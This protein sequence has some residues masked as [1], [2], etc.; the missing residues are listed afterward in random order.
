MLQKSRIKSNDHLKNFHFREAC[1]QNVLEEGVYLLYLKNPWFNSACTLFIRAPQNFRILMDFR[2]KESNCDSSSV[3]YFKSYI[4]LEKV[5]DGL[6]S[7]DSQKRVHYVLMAN[8]SPP[9]RQKIVQE[10]A[11]ND[12]SREYDVCHLMNTNP[13]IASSFNVAQILYRLEGDESYVLVKVTFAPTEPDC[14][15]VLY[16]EIE[17]RYVLTNHAKSGNCSWLIAGAVIITI[18]DEKLVQ[19]E[20]VQHKLVKSSKF[21]GKIVKFRGRRNTI[22][23]KMD[24]RLF[25]SRFQIANTIGQRRMVSRF[26]AAQQNNLRE[27]K[28]LVVQHMFLYIPLK[29]VA[30][31]K[32]TRLDLVTNNNELQ[33]IKFDLQ[34]AND[35]EKEPFSYGPL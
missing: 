19:S 16:G 6:K 2:S 15:A 21:L 24:K 4:F 11:K 18:D 32:F 13:R 20:E 34:F 31:C 26:D 5:I 27:A 7:F 33:Y 25:E 29:I 3:K 35:Y 17:G 8:N 14:N 1:V 23:I 30:P 10:N 12:A 22:Q 9:R 28:T